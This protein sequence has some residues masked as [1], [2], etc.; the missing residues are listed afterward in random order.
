IAEELARL[1]DRVPPFPGTT[2]RAIIEKSLG[3]TIAEMFSEFDETP[4]A[5][6][7]VAQVHAARLKPEKP[8]EPGF[9]VVVKVIR[10][11]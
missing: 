6:A 4:L 11:G 5:S 10:P 3:K 8:G 7:S 9:E 2:A 1:Q